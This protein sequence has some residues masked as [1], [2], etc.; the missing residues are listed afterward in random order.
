VNR[1]GFI[2]GSIDSKHV[3]NHL[4]IGMQRAVADATQVNPQRM[5]K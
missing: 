4:E 2:Q 3:H 5:P 1:A